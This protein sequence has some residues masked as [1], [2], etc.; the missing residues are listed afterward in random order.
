MMF[1]R[2]DSRCNQAAPQET[3]GIFAKTAGGVTVGVAK[4]LIASGEF[5]G[6]IRRVFVSPATV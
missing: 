3:E 5:R 1:G 6:M 2:R 4:K